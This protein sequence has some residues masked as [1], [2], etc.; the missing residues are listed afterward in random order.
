MLF[1]VMGAGIVAALSVAATSYISRLIPLSPFGASVVA[2][3]F[4]GVLA[5]VNV[6]GTRRSA[7]LTNVTTAVKVG[8]ILV[9]SIAFVAGP[10]VPNPRPLWPETISVST[11]SGFG[12][13]M[14]G[15]LWAFEGWQW[16]TFV[17]GET[18]DAQRVFPRAM[19]IGTL[20]GIFGYVVANVGYLAALGPEAMAQSTAVAADAAL[21]TFGPTASTF[22]ALLAIVT[23]VGAANGL[24][25]TVPR[26]FFAMA[27]DGIFFRTLARVHPRFGTPAASIVAVALVGA[28]LTLSGTFDQLLTYVVFTGWI[29][30]ML[31]GI[32]LFVFRRRDPHAPRPYRVPGYPLTPLVFVISALG[33]VLNTIVAQ[34]ARAAVGL[35]VVALGVPVYYL[36]ARDARNVALSSVLLAAV[37]W[38]A[39]A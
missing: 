12:A 1:F 31:A 10:G 30:Y 32:S 21:R 37:A 34:P 20:L 3:A 17:V 18:V 24:L 26:V 13:A 19:I 27:N 2:I 8:V 33:V 29:F 11:V 25:L 9:V 36:W 14:L 23:I 15:V 38:T 35:G 22:V 28:L 39:V 7:R 4:I 16:A 6:I 5:T